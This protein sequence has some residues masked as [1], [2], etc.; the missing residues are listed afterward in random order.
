[1]LQ[2]YSSFLT[3]VVF[4]LV[5]DLYGDDFH[6]LCKDKGKK[7]AGVEKST[8]AQNALFF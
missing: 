3:P 4:S 2:K 7:E 6:P 1:M 5:E 8:P